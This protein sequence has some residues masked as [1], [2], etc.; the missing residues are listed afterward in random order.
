MRFYRARNL[1]VHYGEIDN[2][3]TRL[4]EDAQYYL[5]TCVGRVLH[6]LTVFNQWGVNTS[7]EFQRQRFESLI[8][9]MQKK[10]T[11]VRVDELRVHTDVGNAA[12]LV[13]PN[14]TRSGRPSVET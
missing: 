8:E 13:W 11:E 12:D 9:R 14:F 5:S 3:A 10:P 2:L 7:L 6:D 1:L 4:L